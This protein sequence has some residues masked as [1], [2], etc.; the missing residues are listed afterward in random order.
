MHEIHLNMIKLIVGDTIYPQRADLTRL[1]GIA[2]IDFPW[3]KY[4]VQLHKPGRTDHW[5][6]PILGGCQILSK[7]E[8]IKK[9]FFATICLEIKSAAKCEAL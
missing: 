2:D 9:I 3:L 1:S 8:E 7:K 6:Q 4:H 5:C